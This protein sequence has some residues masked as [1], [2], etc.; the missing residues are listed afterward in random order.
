MGNGIDYINHTYRTA[1]RVGSRV[2]YTGDRSGERFGVVMGAQGGHLLVRI[3]GSDH[4]AWAHPTWRMSI[5]ESR[6]FSRE[7]YDGPP[8]W[9]TA[10][11]EAMLARRPLCDE[12]GTP[13]D[14]DADCAE[15]DGDGGE[16]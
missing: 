6:V 2:R 15:D 5:V 8:A 14:E 7:G 9:W 12:H 4:L 11:Q 10:H 16:E 3:D 1:Y 13:L